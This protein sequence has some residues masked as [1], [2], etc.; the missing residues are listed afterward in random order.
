MTNSVDRARR[1]IEFLTKQ[2]A[3]PFRAKL[4]RHFNAGTITRLCECGCHSFDLEIPDDVDLPRIAPR[5]KS[6]MF[7]RIVY[8]SDADAEVEFFFFSDSR[9]YLAG[10]DVMC[11]SGSNMPDD[12]KLGRVLSA[13]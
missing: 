9:G 10:I 7:F 2:G 1:W 8:E 12:V 13:G 5:R 6:G 3:V 4:W 11:V